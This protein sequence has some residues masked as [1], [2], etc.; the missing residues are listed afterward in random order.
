MRFF[1]SMLTDGLEK[2]WQTP[3]GFK[4]SSEELTLRV[5]AFPNTDPVSEPH[6]TNAVLEKAPQA[7]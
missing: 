1:L 3:D 5:Q 7:R 2:P 4:G 6:Q